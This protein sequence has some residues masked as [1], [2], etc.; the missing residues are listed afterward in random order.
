MKYQRTRPPRRC[1]YH[2]PRKM[3][4][5]SNYDPGSH[6]RNAERLLSRGFNHHDVADAFGIS[7]TCFKEWME[8]YDDFSA[9]VRQGED[10]WWR[11]KVV[12]SLRLNCTGFIKPEE[13]IFYNAVQDKVVRVETSRYYPPNIT[14]IIFYLCN[15]APDEFR[16]INRDKPADE[17]DSLRELAEILRNGPVGNAPIMEEQPGAG[18]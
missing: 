13:K 3:G 12:K 10:K 4:R 17:T 2:K 7:I 9:A 1:D 11:T 15:K 6:P 5:P 16:S 18:A 8:R 14:S